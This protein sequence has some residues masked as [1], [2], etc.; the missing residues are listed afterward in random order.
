MITHYT[1][2][3]GILIGLGNINYLL[4]GILYN[5]HECYLYPP[6]FTLYKFICNLILVSTCHNCIPP[7]PTNIVCN[8]GN[9]VPFNILCQS[10]GFNL[11]YYGMMNPAIIES[12]IVNPRSFQQN[13]WV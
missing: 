2:N 3:T 12:I 7:I 10:L 6:I 11:V 9:W 4:P 13:L 1:I 8:K 5:I